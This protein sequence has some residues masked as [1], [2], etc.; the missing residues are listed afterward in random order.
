[1]HLGN[2]FFLHAIIEELSV[3]G[4]AIGGPGGAMPPPPNS[5]G[6]GAVMYLAPPPPI[7]RENSVMYTINVQCF[8]LKKTQ[9]NVYA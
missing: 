6:G 5:N 8:S 3:M 1:M 9:W 7:F 2:N 4:S